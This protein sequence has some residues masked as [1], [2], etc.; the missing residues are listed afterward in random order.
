M[1]LLSW[2]LK[3]VLTEAGAARAVEAK[4]TITAFNFI[5]ADV[6][7]WLKMAMQFIYPREQKLR[8]GLLVTNSVSVLP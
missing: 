3:P 8:N 2:R 7:M 1:V 5:F 6:K 4:A